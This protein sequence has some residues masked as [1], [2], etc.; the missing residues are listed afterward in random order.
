MLRRLVSALQSA[1]EPGVNVGVS[2][3]TCAARLQSSIFVRRKSS[4][5]VNTC[6][7][8]SIFFGRAESGLLEAC[9]GGGGR[10]ACGRNAVHER[11]ALAPLSRRSA[12]FWP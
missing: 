11:F 3:A 2:F 8:S 9:A 1:R 12:L 10:T 6:I 5:I 4:M 7:A